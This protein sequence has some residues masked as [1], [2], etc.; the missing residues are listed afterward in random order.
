MPEIEPVNTGFAVPYTFED[1]AGV[2]VRIAGLT[3]KVTDAVA[4]L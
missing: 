4:V 2:T 1:G 3:V